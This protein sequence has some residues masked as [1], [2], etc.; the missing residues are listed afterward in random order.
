MADGTRRLRC[1]ITNGEKHTYF[2]QLFP[3]AEVDGVDDTRYDEADEF[4]ELFLAVRCIAEYEP[5]TLKEGE[6]WME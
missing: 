4:M 1:R 3:A 5:L 2:H 6:W